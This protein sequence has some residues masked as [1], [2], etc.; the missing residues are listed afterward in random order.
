[1]NIKQRNLTITS[2]LV[3]ATIAGSSVAPLGRTDPDAEP[4][5]DVE[6]VH[7]GRLPGARRPGIKHGGHAHFQPPAYVPPDLSKAF[8]ELDGVYQG[9]AD[10][11]TNDI[12]DVKVDVAYTVRGTVI[13]IGELEH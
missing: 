5:P 1:M 2:V 11:L 8:P 7:T 6:N 9:V 3:L 12:R 10:F 4:A 13:N